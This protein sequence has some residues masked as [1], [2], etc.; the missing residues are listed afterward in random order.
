M[1]RD[2]QDPLLLEMELSEAK[3]D[4]KGLTA[5]VMDSSS[6]VGRILETQKMTQQSISAIWTH[7]GMLSHP[8]VPLL[9][10]R[11]LLPAPGPS[12]CMSTP[13]RNTIPQTNSSRM[14]LTPI[15]LQFADMEEQ[16]FS[17]NIAPPQPL[18]LKQS[19]SAAKCL[20]SSEIKTERLRPVDE[21]LLLNAKYRALNKASTLAVK[22]ARDAIFG[23]EILY[24]CTISGKRG[25]R[26][27][28]KMSC[29]I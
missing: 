17:P 21:V 19:S 5:T 1:S 23:E 4:L 29:K 14:P 10:Q 18:P 13:V 16:A 6:A 3:E 25:S 24:L 8:P 22:L 28:Y 7:L 27:Y 15:N 11:P 2:Y 26:D 9:Y 12:T 20:P